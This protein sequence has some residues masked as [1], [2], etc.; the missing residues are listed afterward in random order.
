MAAAIALASSGDAWA[1]K[2]KPR[3]KR[4]TASTSLAAKDYDGT[5]IIMQGL[6]PTPSIMVEEPG[7]KK[8]AA[9][10]TTRPRGSSTYIPPPIP[11]PDTPRAVVPP[12]P[13]PYRPPPVNS[14]GDRA[15]GCIHSFPLNAGIGNNP[16]DQSSY[17]RQCAN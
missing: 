16:T 12:N 4:D 7:S 3:A 8:R 6:G 2:K 15:T 13:Q 10:P 14:Y 1:A 9:K 5:P 11:S 17:V